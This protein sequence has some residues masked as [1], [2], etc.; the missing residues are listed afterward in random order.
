L[1]ELLKVRTDI[2]R[3]TDGIITIAEQDGRTVCLFSDELIG[4]QQVVVKALP[5]YI[6][7]LNKTKALAGCTLLGDGSISLILDITGLANIKGLA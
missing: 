4:Q 5:E 2:T 1:H 3:F 6:R 7:K